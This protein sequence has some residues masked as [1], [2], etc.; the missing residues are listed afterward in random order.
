[1]STFAWYQPGYRHTN[2]SLAV[3]ND[4][5]G[6][7]IPSLVLKHPGSYGLCTALTF[8][9]SEG[10][11]ST[12]LMAAVARSNSQSTVMYRPVVVSDLTHASILSMSDPS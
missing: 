3:G 10:S 7:S 4:E 5:C 9:K 12:T 6:M 1:M 8:T 2:A 11:L